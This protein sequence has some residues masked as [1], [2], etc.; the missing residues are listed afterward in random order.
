M[1]LEPPYV[2]VEVCGGA[3]MDRKTLAAYAEQFGLE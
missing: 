2:V 3:I 1:R